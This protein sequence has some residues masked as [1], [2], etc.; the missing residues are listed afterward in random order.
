[1]VLSLLSFS[2]STYYSDL[3]SVLFFIFC[4]CYPFVIRFFLVS[5]SSSSSQIIICLLLYFFLFFVPRLLIAALLTRR[6]SASFRSSP[7]L[8]LLTQYGRRF[9]QE[10]KQNIG[11]WEERLPEP[12]PHFP[13]IW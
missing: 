4:R 12:I 7:P 5:S 3:L 1:M 11:E 9:K 8:S 2:N 6:I 13:S 10:A